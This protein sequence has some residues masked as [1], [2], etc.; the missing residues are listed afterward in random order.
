MSMFYCSFAENPILNKT[1]LPHSSH[2]VNF[3]YCKSI[4]DLVRL[5]QKS[6][7]KRSFCYAS[8]NYKGNVCKGL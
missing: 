2:L 6:I 1:E 5:S 7:R 8:G 3:V 4:A